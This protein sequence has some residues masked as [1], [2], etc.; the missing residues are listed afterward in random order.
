MLDVV[1]NPE[2]RI[3][4]NQAQMK[5]WDYQFGVHLTFCKAWA[6]TASLKNLRCIVRKP[7]F[8]LC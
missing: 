5:A 8:I 7:A 4:H 3:S 1:G 6:H 2:D